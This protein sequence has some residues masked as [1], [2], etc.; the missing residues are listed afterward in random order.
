MKALTMQDLGRRGGL[1]GGPAR[2]RKLSARKRSAIAKTAATARW[3]P[4][5]LTL[6]PPR[7][8]EEVHC[9]VAQYGNGYARAKEGCDPVVVLL[10][11]LTAC[12]NDA[13]LARMLP[14]FIYRA[15]L[16]IFKDQQR[17]LAVPQKEARVLGYFLELTCR[18]GKLES[19][20]QL[21]SE[22]RGKMRGPAV[23]LFH[24][25]LAA[26]RTSLLADT[27]KLVLGESDASFESYFK[28]MLSTE[29]PVFKQLPRL[30]KAPRASL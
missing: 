5:V 14:V 17:L 30:S 20:R 19:P 12:R 28:K 21:L 4:T 26:P 27:W 7:D 6:V 16:E 23:F 9:F 11:A 25:A 24:K 29:D 2:A 10:Q 15:R 1:R 13:G 18:L 22:L 3:K 8:L